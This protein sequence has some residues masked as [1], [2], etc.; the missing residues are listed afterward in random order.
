VFAIHHNIVGEIVRKFFFPLF[1][2]QPTPVFYGVSFP[3]FAPPGR[4]R[5]LFIENSLPVFFEFKKGKNIL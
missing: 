3:Q 1:G 2:G 4:G 5:S